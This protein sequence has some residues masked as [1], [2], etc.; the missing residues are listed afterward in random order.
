MTVVILFLIHI[1][2]F[3]RV[4]DNLEEGRA[5]IVFTSIL[6]VLLCWQVAP[7]YGL[8][9]AIYTFVFFILLNILKNNQL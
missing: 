1:I 7:I 4:I 6:L 8:L 3:V 9:T 5:R 2:Y